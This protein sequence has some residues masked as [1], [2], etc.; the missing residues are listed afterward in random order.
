MIVLGIDP[1]YER[2]GISV[3]ERGSSKEKLLYSSCFKTTPKDSHAKRLKEIG[4]EIERII[5]KFKPDALA[6]E[7]LFFNS[8]QKTVMLVSEAKGTVLF[9]AAKHSLDIFEYSPPQIKAAITGNGKSDKKAI[10]KMVPLLIKISK[11][12][13]HDDEYDAIAIALT[14]LATEKY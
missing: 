11:D 8:N 5:E 14:C 1:G 13:K 12:I 3:I 9:C 6:I 7:T 4:L 10:I 2:L